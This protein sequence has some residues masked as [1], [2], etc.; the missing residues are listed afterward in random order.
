MGNFKKLEVWE[1]ACDLAVTIHKLVGQLPT[2]EKFGLISQARRAAMSIPQNIAE[3]S[4]RGTDADFARF[5][6]ISLG[7]AAELETILTV[8]PRLHHVIQS[9][10]DQAMA[11]LNQVQRLL[12]NLSQQWARNTYAS[13]RQ[14][15]RMSLT[16]NVTSP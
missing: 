12:R 10:Y 1:M 15:M 6:R 5:L 8:A 9:D 4:A 7:S 16:K 3:G 14:F 2:D 13:R 11:N